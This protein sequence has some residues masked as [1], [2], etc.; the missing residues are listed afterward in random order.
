MTLLVAVDVAGLVERKDEQNGVALW[1]SRRLTI[2][3]IREHCSGVRLRASSSWTG[4]ALMLV[5][6]TAATANS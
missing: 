5:A 2:F 3:F 1:T 6:A 4:E